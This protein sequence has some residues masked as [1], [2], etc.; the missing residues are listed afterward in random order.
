MNNLFAY[1][2][3]MKDEAPSGLIAEK[4]LSEKSFEEDGILTESS[5]FWI[6]YEVVAEPKGLNVRPKRKGFI[7]KCQ[8]SFWLKINQVQTSV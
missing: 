2:S 6:S 8:E 7:N 5:E 3:A 1:V 4:A